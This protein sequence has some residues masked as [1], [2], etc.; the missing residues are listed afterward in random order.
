MLGGCKVVITDG[1]YKGRSGWVATTTYDNGYITYGVIIDFGFNYER[2]VCLFRN[3]VA[4]EKTYILEQIKKVENS[5]KH[6][7][8]QKDNYYKLLKESIKY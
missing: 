6:F 8:K 5:I 4:P 7:T 3:Q 2:E 1:E